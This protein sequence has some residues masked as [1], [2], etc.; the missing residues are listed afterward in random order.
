MDKFADELANGQKIEDTFGRSRVERLAAAMV[1]NYA[2][3]A[4]G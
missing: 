4:S 1:K 2:F 3:E